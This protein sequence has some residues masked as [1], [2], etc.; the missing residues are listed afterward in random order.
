MDK[1]ID[2][3]TAKPLAAFMKAFQAND[4][5]INSLSVPFQANP[6]R[7][8]L[9]VR[10]GFVALAWPRGADDEHQ[11]KPT[12]RNEWQ[13]GRVAEDII[14]KHR[15]VHQVDPIVAIPITPMH[16]GTLG[17][18]YRGDI[19][20]E[21]IVDHQYYV[22]N[23]KNAVTVAVSVMLTNANCTVWTVRINCRSHCKTNQNTGE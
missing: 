14:Y 11:T 21:G 12:S 6:D 13:V 1:V 15:N 23:I 7:L 19:T 10:R 18:G 16:V 22:G 17:I 4:V 2:C 20:L 8:D 5:H 3:H 9:N